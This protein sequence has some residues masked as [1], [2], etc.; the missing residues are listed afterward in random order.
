[1][2]NIYIIVLK[3]GYKQQDLNPDTIRPNQVNFGA[4]SLRAPGPKIWNNLSQPI[5]SPENHSTSNNLLKSWDSV[6]CQCHL[7][8][9][10]EK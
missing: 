5:K 3:Q 4:K 9:T 6:S 1:M 10:F 8:K 7:C 2:S